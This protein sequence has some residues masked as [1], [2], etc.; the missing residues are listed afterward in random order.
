MKLSRRE[1][2][3]WGAASAGS[4]LLARNAQAATTITVNGS[5]GSLAKAIEDLYNQPFTARTGIEVRSTAPTSLPKLKAMIETGNMEWDLTEM[6][7][8]DLI[9]AAHNGWLSEIDWSVVDPKSQLP[10]VAK[11]KFAM[12]TATFSTVMAYRTDKFG[13]RTPQSW[14]D[15]WDVKKFPGGRALQDSPVHNLEFA[16]L[17]DGV[18]KDKLYPIDVDRAFRKLDQIKP[19]VVTWWATGAQQVQLLLDGE[20]T[21]GTVWNGRVAPLKRENKPVEISWEG[22]ALQPSFWAIP[23]GAKHPREAMMYMNGRLDVDK[24]VEFLK[25]SPYPG[26]TPGLMEKVP[27]DV[28]RTLPTYPE[29]LAKQYN[30]SP[31]FWADNRAALTQRW[32][33]WLLK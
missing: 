24:A 17:A 23:K 7:G 22:G 2:S 15:F 29:N 21:M 25:L 19:H 18:S 4:L 9:Q 8:D 10:A 32:N 16:L 14:A 30:Y 27:V 12:V 20:V 6:T 33:A 31:E 5:G 13:G 3:S 1:F 11:Q 28:A 26:F